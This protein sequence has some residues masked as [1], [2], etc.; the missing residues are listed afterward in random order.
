[1]CL[2]YCLLHFLFSM[3]LNDLQETLL[4][5]GTDGI[6]I[7]TLKLFVLL[8][9]DDLI[10]FA[11]SAEGLQN[12]L[13][14]LDSYCDRWKLVVNTQKTK[15]MI[16]R[17]AGRLPQNLMFF[18]QGSP[19]EIVSKFKYL[20]V[21]FS[22]GGAFNENDKTT[23]GQALKAIFQMN[24]YLYK[25]TYI[26]PKIQFDLFDKL[27]LPILNYSTEVT[28]FNK[29]SHCERVHLNYCK[30]LL[31]VKICTQNNFV[32]G[33]TGRLPL[34]ALWQVNIVRYWLKLCSM[35]DTKY[36]KIVYN[37]LVDQINDRPNT[38]NWASNV[39]DLLS[40]L[41]F[42]EV[43]LSQGVGNSK[44]FL[45]LFKQRVKDTY[46][47]TWNEQLQ[48]SSRSLF[49]KEIANFEYK[50]YLDI[51][52]IPKFRKA[53]TRLRLSSH[54][55]EIE[56]GRWSK[57]HRTPINERKCPFCNKLEDEFHFVIECPVYADLRKDLIKPYYWIRPNFI[58]FVEL[59]NA[60]NKTVITKLSTY[61]FK[62]FE[63]RQNVLKYF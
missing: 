8:Y 25:F 38:R 29:G 11:K 3:F 17:N 32:Y 48:N 9:A 30:R 49:Y 26:S 10:L 28:G 60:T 40:R 33:K 45:N 57:P 42:Y 53:L 62:A 20:G 27:V 43:W 19:I 7:G 58:K 6:D 13:N 59:I 54:R 63:T 5:K 61:T 47:Q 4:L 22:S 37:F 44:V 52:K 23:S 14:I 56:T 2:A 55:L 46:I 1:M 39:K 31:G 51:I 16:F 36:P 24:K 21:V 18:Y 12:S 15:I 41:G 35:F 50:A 34:N